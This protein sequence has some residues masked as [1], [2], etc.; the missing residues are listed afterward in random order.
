MMKAISKILIIAIILA[1]L[2]IGSVSYIYFSGILRPAETPVTTPTPALPKLVRIGTSEVGGIGYVISSIFANEMKNA[3]PAVITSVYVVGGYPIQLKEFA[4]GN[5]ELAWVG[6]MSLGPA[7]KREPPYDTIPKDKL[8]VT[9]FIVTHGYYV[10]ATTPELKTKL[11]INSWRDLDGK[12]VS[13]WASGWGVHREF[14]KTLKLL[15]INV[16]HKELGVYSEKQID[17]LKK[18][19]I[20]AIG[21]HAPAGFPAPGALTVLTRMDLVI[22]NP[23]SEDA[24]KVMKAGLPFLWLPTSAVNWT[25][26][27][28]V[29]KMFTLVEGMGWHTL[30]RILSEDFVYK[31]WKVLITNKDKL[32][33][34]S[35]YFKMFAEDPIKVI[36]AAISLI[37]YVPVHPGTAKLLKEYNAWN[38][39]WKIA[40]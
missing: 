6:T 36:V 2:V 34:Q 9:T 35:L 13:L 37:P 17:A 27:M 33:Q 5:L 23:S 21:L 19:D 12:P 15:N 14:M 40:E 11:N 4:E 7:W 39:E 18:G 3:F 10:L 38:P 22:I 26:P 16:E 32:A 29:D 30:P 20:V 8:P 28:G 24:E 1:I 31:M 25:K